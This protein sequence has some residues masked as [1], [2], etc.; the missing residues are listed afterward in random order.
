MGK[1][2]DFAENNLLESLL[3]VFVL[4]AVVSLI[5]YLLM[6]ANIKRKQFQLGRDSLSE[7][8][9]AK[10]QQISSHHNEISELK[11]LKEKMQLQILQLS[12]TEAMLVERLEQFQKLATKS[13]ILQTELNEQQKLNIEL[14]SNLEAQLQK[15]KE[16]QQFVTNAEK[17]LKDQ[18][19]RLS[20]KV[21]S[22]KSEKFTQQ[23]QKNIDQLLKPMKQQFVD[24]QKSVQDLN[25][26]GATQH[27]IMQTELEQMR[28][29]NLN[30]SQQALDL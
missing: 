23:N 27:K 28:K 18:F 5:V 12:K 4:G 19:H 13:E 14:N 21:L 2:L 16:Q 20:E 10:E 3:L 15:T 1:I 29:S 11:Q 9:Q 22:E 30:I 26:K 25:I 7:T 24:F 6:L 8:L 17:T